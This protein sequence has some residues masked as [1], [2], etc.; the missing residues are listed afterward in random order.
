MKP[1]NNRRTYFLSMASQ[2]LLRIG[3]GIHPSASTPINSRLHNTER[4]ATASSEAAPCFDTVFSGL[5]PRH[6]FKKALGPPG[7]R[8]TV[9]LKMRPLVWSN[10]YVAMAC[11][12]CRLLQRVI[13][14]F[15]AFRVWFKG[16]CRSGREYLGWTDHQGECWR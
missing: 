7:A 15:M 11:S 6:L 8:W 5:R 14:N 4:I 1:K 12:L 16:L 10:L 3:T 2:I 13:V 9:S